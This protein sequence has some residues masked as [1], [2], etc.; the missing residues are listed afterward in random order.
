MILAK[1][2]SKCHTSQG[3]SSLSTIYPPIPPIAG[4]EQ[5]FAFDYDVLLGTI[6]VYQTAI[7]MMYDLAQ[8]SF[9]QSVKAVDSRQV[10]NYHVLIF[11][12]NTQPTSSALQLQ[13]KHCIYALYEAIQVMTD[14]IVFAQMR[15]QLKVFGDTVGAL[16]IDRLPPAAAAEAEVHNS[17]TVSLR[18][19]TDL[20]STTPSKDV[21]GT[22]SGRYTDPDNP[23]FVIDYHFL[24]KNITPKEVSLAVLEALTAAAPHAKIQPFVELSVVSPSGGCAIIIEGRTSKHILTYLWATRALKLLYQAIVVP[25]KRFGDVYLRLMYLGEEIGELRML[26]GK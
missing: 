17:S 2:P 14:G 6:D 16:S 5:T 26:R 15:S 25:Q 20:A 3:N 10:G 7:Q 22:A 19:G 21:L 18:E 23:Q 9:V 11:F 4:F 12:I 13:V 24:G 1:I 8:R